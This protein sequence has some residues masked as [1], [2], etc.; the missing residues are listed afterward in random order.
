MGGRKKNLMKI[1]HPRSKFLII[2]QAKEEEKSIKIL[3]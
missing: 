2:M 1:S 3:L